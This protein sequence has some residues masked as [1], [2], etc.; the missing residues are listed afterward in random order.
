M[1]SLNIIIILC[2]SE[3]GSAVEHIGEK[4]ALLFIVVRNICV[5]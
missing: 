3:L 1:Q 5:L 4:A 2:V